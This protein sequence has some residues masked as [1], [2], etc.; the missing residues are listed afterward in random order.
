MNS[1]T[2][3]TFISF[4]DDMTI[5]E[6][7]YR[8]TIP[9]L[10]NEED[11]SEKLSR[12]FISK[13]DIEEHCAK[14]HIGLRIGVLLE[15]SRR[16]RFIGEFENKFKLV[17]EINTIKSD[18]LDEIVDY[19]VNSSATSITIEKEYNKRIGNLYESTNNDEIL[20]GV[21]CNVMRVIFGINRTRG[22][23]YFKNAY[24][25]PYKGFDE[26]RDTLDYTIFPQ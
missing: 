20:G 1:I 21:T 8:L 5:A 12:Y 11:I 14:K 18:K 16:S 7:T 22:Y 13:K 23:F 10:H 19:I 2:V 6:E 24:P 9:N 26:K 17:N 25:I 3:E 15:K 4:C